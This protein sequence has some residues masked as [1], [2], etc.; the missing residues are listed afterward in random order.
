MSMSMRTL[1]AATLGLVTALFVASSAAPAR[2]Q[3]ASTEDLC[4]PDV[5]RLCSEFVPER[6]K[7]TACLRRKWRAVSK[8]CR[9]GMASYGGG[10]GKS[11]RRHHR[12]KS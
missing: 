7:I 9:G 12:K 1:S 10:K 11:K 3:G 8:E 4:T 6:D 2:A 5:M